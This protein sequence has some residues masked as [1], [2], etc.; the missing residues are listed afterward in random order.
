M[1]ALPT[2][3]SGVELSKFPEHEF[4]E[5]RRL[6]TPSCS[7]V[8]SSGR[9]FAEPAQTLVFLDWDDTLFPC[10][11]LFARRGL[12][13]R[14]AS[15]PLT[16]FPAG[17]DDELEEW[18]RA[19]EDF[20]TTVCT[21]SDRCVIVT[22]SKPPWVEVCVRQF[23]PNLR[24]FFDRKCERSNPSS[25]RPLVA[26]AGEVFRET[27]AAAAAAS[28]PR[29]PECSCSCS[30]FS[31]M[32]RYFCQKGLEAD[33]TIEDEDFSSRSAEL[34]AAKRETM[35]MEAHTFYSRYPGQTWKNIVSLGDMHYEHDAVK[36]LAKNRIPAQSRERL[37]IKSM[38]TLASPSL[39]ELTTQL[40]LW[41]LLFPVVARFDGDLDLHVGN[42]LWPLKELSHAL[43]MPHLLSI[44]SAA[45]WAS[46]RG[47]AEHES[48]EEAATSEI[49]AALDELAVALQYSS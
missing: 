15:W 43:Q 42:S 39:G 34:T 24:K 26:Y 41:Q 14:A 20:L 31:S 25:R 37:R 1:S 38:V 46:R 19:V 9:D 16:R 35:R 30:S 47:E 21:I 13:R 7:S 28:R 32:A 5:F 3:A 2:I 45:P 22:N 44:A 10:S 40:R 18:R 11:E 48:C 27:R 29:P 12:S 4:A 17:L 49:D 8:A 6:V 33:P 36:A 23:A